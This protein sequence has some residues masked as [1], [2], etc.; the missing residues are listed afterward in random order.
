M[1]LWEGVPLCVLVW[2]ARPFAKGDRAEIQPLPLH[3]VDRG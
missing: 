2:M 1:G 3:V